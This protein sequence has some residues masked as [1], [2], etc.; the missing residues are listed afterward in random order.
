MK[1]TT[2]ASPRAT[3]KPR[4][5]DAEVGKEMELHQHQNRYQHLD[6]SPNSISGFGT[7]HILQSENAS[8]AIIVD[9]MSPAKITDADRD[10]NGT[11]DWKKVEKRKMKKVRNLE[12]KMSVCM[13]SKA[14]GYISFYELALF[15]E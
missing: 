14:C 1:R 6:S 2:S 9:D 3:K 5:D 12:L 15:T 7:D 11:H 8:E 13:S 4:L 10:A